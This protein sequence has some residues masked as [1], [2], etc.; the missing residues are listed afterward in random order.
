MS[1]ARNR[2]FI[3]IY[4]LL[5]GCY[6]KYTDSKH[7]LLKSRSERSMAKKNENNE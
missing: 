2:N 3:L 5:V 7:D 4:S 1:F 6:R